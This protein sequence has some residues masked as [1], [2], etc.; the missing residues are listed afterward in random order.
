MIMRKDNLMGNRVVVV[1]A[2][3]LRDKALNKLGGK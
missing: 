3:F 1:I 2:V